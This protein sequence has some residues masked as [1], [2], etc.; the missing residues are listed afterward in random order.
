[1]PVVMQPLAHQRFHRRGTTPEIV[2]DSRR[3]LLRPID[4]PDTR[5]ALIAEAAREHDFSKI[6]LPH[7][8]DR[9]PNPGAGTNLCTGLDYLLV[10]PREIY[11]LSPFPNIVGNRLL[12]VDIFARL[13]RPDSGQ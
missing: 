8:L 7:P 5:T 9:F 1:M 2:I 3:N 13:Y 11:Q 10:V 4:F 12:D 6:P